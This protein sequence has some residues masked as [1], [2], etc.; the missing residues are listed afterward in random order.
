[1][2][3]GSQMALIN[4]TFKKKERKKEGRKKCLDDKLFHKTSNPSTFK[5]VVC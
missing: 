3:G 4:V 2:Q 1:M 5:C